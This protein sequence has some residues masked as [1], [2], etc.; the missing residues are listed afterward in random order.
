MRNYAQ[1][2]PQFWI[3]E[4]GRFFRKC[5]LE[6]QI[7]ALYLITSPHANMIGLYYLPKAFIAHET[8]LT[9]E[10]VS[11]GLQRASEAG[12]ARYDEDTETVF[13]PNF[14]RFQVGQNLSV[15]DNTVIGIA[16]KLLEM[17]KSPFVK[18]FMRIYGGIYKL[19]DRE[20]LKGL[21]SPLQAPPKP[22][23]SQEQKQ[24]QN[25]GAEKNPAPK[26]TH[27][28]QTSSPDHKLAVTYW[29]ERFQEIF[30]TPYAFQS[31][32]DGKIISLL[33]RGYGLEQTKRIIDRFLTVKEDFYDRGPGRTLGVLWSN[34][35]KL[36]VE[37]TEREDRFSNQPF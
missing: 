36:S 5:G 7:L 27:R 3:G 2:A 18:D 13:I 24:E 4:T 10:G 9:E 20:E 17:R 22:L 31:G 25:V 28:K 8:G 33:L 14:V 12:F 23:R 16:K 1:V 19:S 35:N 30:K 34:V 6:V 21:L 11:K 32:K 37:V 29:R 26:R 15:S